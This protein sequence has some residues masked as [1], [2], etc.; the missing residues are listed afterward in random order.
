MRS[1]AIYEKCVCGSEIKLDEQY[2]M[3]SHNLTEVFLAWRKEHRDCVP[4][5]HQ[6]QRAKLNG[7]KRLGVGQ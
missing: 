4:L 2:E 6:V 7:L 3:F 5:F 1:I